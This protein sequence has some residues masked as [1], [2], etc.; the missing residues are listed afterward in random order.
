MRIGGAVLH[1]LKRSHRAAELKAPAHICKRHVEALLRAANLLR[2]KRNDG[3]QPRLFAT[4]RGIRRAQLASRRSAEAQVR[5]LAGEVQRRG[6]RNFDA[7]RIGGDGKKPR[8]LCRARANQQQRRI[9]R[10]HHEALRAVQAPAA[11]LHARRQRQRRES[12]APRN[13]GQQ[14]RLLCRGGAVLQRQ[15][16]ELRGK[17]RPARELAAQLFQRNAELE[18][19]R[20]LPAVL[21]GHQQP[22]QAQLRSQRAPH[23]RLE[24]ARRICQ[25]PRLCNRPALGG[26]AAQRFAE[27]LLLVA[28]CEVHAP[29]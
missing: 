18:K 9:L 26:E 16:A 22:G 25:T 28:E 11:K 6:G 20:P 23:F 27:A 3:L 17:E 5:E 21:F 19:R 13:A 1:R 7:G 24:A 12:L 15:H 4:G 14:L 10:I 8:A 2:R 29:P